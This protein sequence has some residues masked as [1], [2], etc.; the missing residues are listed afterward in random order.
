[1]KSVLLSITIEYTEHKNEIYFM[2]LLSKNNEIRPA[3]G[4]FLYINY[5]H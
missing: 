3:R 4:T 2:R 1:M 5:F